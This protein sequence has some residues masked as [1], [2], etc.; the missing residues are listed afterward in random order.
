VADSVV[1]IPI[2][3]PSTGITVP[4]ATNALGGCGIIEPAVGRPAR[5]DLA[6]GAIGIVQSVTSDGYANVIT[7]GAI[8]LPTASWDAVTD[9]SGGP[10]GPGLIPGSLYYV[11]PSGG[12]TPHLPQIGV[13]HS[14]GIALTP[15]IMQVIV[16]SHETPPERSRWTV[17]AHAAAEHLGWRVEDM[18]SSHTPYFDGGTAV[19]RRLTAGAELVANDAAREV[20]AAHDILE[21]SERAWVAARHAQIDAIWKDEGNLVWAVMTWVPTDN[22]ALSMRNFYRGAS[23]ASAGYGYVNSR[24]RLAVDSEQCADV[25]HSLITPMAS[26]AEAYL[27]HDVRVQ[28]LVARAAESGSAS[29]SIPDPL[30]DYDSGPIDMDD[31]D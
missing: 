22:I 7:Q 8:E 26:K 25:F 18:F 30:D 16:S 29:N 15:T 12:L 5:I 14:V 3:L 1:K 2:A 19:L 21:P 20:E 24:Y 23:G 31:E 4:S 13:V 9:N 6:H 10:V 28:M 17:H 11:S 27:L